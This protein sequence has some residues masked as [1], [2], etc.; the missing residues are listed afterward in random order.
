M[1]L[2]IL[3]VAGLDSLHD[4]GPIR[5]LGKKQ[6]VFIKIGILCVTY[7]RLVNK[8]DVFIKIGII[9]VTYLRLVNS[10]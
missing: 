8:Q 3:L 5:H 2:K 10:Y 9:C 6:D 4:L 1:S 7:L